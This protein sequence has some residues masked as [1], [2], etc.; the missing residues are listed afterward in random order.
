MLTHHATRRWRTIGALPI[1]LIAAVAVMA[2]AVFVP[3]AGAAPEQ[4]IYTADVGPHSV[5]AGQT[6]NFTLTVRNTS[7]TQQLGSINLTA[8]STFSLISTNQPSPRGTA[9][10]VGTTGG[11]IELRNLALAPA[12]AEAMM[13]T[14]TAEAPCLASPPNYAWSIIAKQSN[15][16]SGSPGNN[17]ITPPAF[18]GLTTA[19]S[20]QCSLSWL[21]QPSHAQT[22]TAITNTPYDDAFGDPGPF[23]IQVEVLSAPGSNGVTRVA[24]STDR[25]DLEIGA[26]PGGLPAALQGTTFTNA[27]NG[28]AT[29]NPGPQI[30]RPGPN[31]T[32]R[33]T[34]PIMVTAESTTFDI[35]DAVCQ[36]PCQTDVPPARGTSAH[37]DAR[38]VPAGGVVAASVGENIQ[39]FACTPSPSPNT[40]VVSVFPQL[41]NPASP[42]TMVIETTFSLDILD[43]PASQVRAC[44]ATVQ[45]FTQANG[46]PSV[47]TTI[48]G[49]LLN[50]GVPP[51]CDNQ[52]PAPPC[53]FPNQRNNQTNQLT[54]RL[55]VAGN[56]PHKR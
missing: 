6:I 4:K 22:N 9:T 52:T 23:F 13:V 47:P 40:Q 35:S 36:T 17:F 24:F 3:G 30:T 33:A 18:P 45:A 15:N 37:I 42:G 8:P 44:L 16:F 26:N 48:A 50:V 55:L 20:G 28:V 12:G 11:R 32:L 39:G 53:F 43:R 7:A 19:V 41:A 54:I 25:V 46:T 5:G 27:V 29:F 34:N 2:T 31:F 21:T 10:R 56:D 49:D 51:D 14:F 1:S 38:N